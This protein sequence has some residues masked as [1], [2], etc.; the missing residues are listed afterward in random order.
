LPLDLTG[1]RIGIGASR[2]SHPFLAV[3]HV[4]SWIT[5]PTRVS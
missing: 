4:Q 1:P 3:C 2:K 5:I